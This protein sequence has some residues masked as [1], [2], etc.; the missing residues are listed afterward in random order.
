[1]STAF[2]TLNELEIR[3]VRSLLN[4]ELPLRPYVEL[5]RMDELH[6]N[7]T[8]ADEKYKSIREA[9][10][11]R[12][13]VQVYNDPD[14]ARMTNAEIV[15]AAMFQVQLEFSWSA[16]KSNLQDEID[17]RIRAELKKRDSE[18]FDEFCRWTSTE[19]GVEKKGH[20][21]EEAAE[22]VLQSCDKSRPVMD[23]M[24]PKLDPT[25]TD[26]VNGLVEYFM[27]MH[28]FESVTP[29][30]VFQASDVTS[31]EFDSTPEFIEPD[32]P[33]QEGDANTEE[34]TSAG[35]TYKRSS[36]P[37][38]WSDEDLITRIYKREEAVE[39]E[40][41]QKNKVEV[42]PPTKE[43]TLATSKKVEREYQ[44]AKGDWNPKDFLEERILKDVINRLEVS[45]RYGKRVLRDFVHG[46]SVFESIL[47]ICAGSLYLMMD[48][49]GSRVTKAD[50][51]YFVQSTLYQ[52]KIRETVSLC[53]QRLSGSYQDNNRRNWRQSEF[54]A[55]RY[56]PDDG[57]DPSARTRRGKNNVRMGGRGYGRY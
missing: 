23:S 26:V 49:D 41:V 24:C 12:F 47:D 4:K 22:L 20:I 48:K 35:G 37:L 1:M 54:F 32:V 19:G 33:T 11:R 34:A 55:D 16:L 2:D 39:S 52:N 43:D 10:I 31:Q 27:Q 5:W 3:D 50:V 6:K 42:E 46:S 14:V 28:D 8:D 13:E 53:E 17:K 21:Y 51:K 45:N 38:T 9:V 29:E 57:Y 7:L 25:I 44:G 36:K 15:K 56:H 40:V 30:D 18:C